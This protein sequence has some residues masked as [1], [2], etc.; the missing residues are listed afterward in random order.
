MIDACD[1]KNVKKID[2]FLFD[3]FGEVKR[4]R[5]RVKN[6]LSNKPWMF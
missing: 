3:F 4:K 2:C 5:C 1:I 6:G